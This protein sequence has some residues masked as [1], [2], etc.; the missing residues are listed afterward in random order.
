M[1]TVMI[2]MFIH[3]QPPTNAH[4]LARNEL[5]SLLYSEEEPV[6]LMHLVFIARA[7]SAML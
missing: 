3:A 6:D 2:Q 1:V 5:R 7:L 4:T